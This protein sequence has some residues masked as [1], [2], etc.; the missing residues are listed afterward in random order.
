MGDGNSEQVTLTHSGRHLP[1]IFQPRN[2]LIVSERVSSE[3]FYF[4]NIELRKV[5]FGK[6]VDLFYEK[7]DFSYYRNGK[8]IDPEDML[9][10][11]PDASTT[12]RDPGVYY[13][14]IVPMTDRIAKDFKETKRIDIYIG[15]TEFDERIVG[16]LSEEMIR[17]YP[18]VWH[19][20]DFICSESV[21]DVLSKHIDWD[22]FLHADI[23]L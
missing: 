5:R 7:R 2:N 9:V 11:L 1:D 8:S 19:D 23:E 15:P 4:E 16:S 20:G 13:E 6:L 10:R 14:L 3:L 12:L 21:F 18:L 17:K 22:F